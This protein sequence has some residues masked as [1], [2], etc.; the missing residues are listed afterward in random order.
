MVIM[1][2]EREV[3]KMNPYFVIGLL[4]KSNTI[5]NHGTKRRK[6][7]RFVRSRVR[8]IFKNKIN[9]NSIYLRI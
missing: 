5:D 8:N 4:L 6:P 7:L 1:V 3:I 9:I 2:C